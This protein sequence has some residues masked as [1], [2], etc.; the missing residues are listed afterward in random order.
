MN[1]LRPKVLVTR[2]DFVPSW[3]WCIVDDYGS[4]SNVSGITHNTFWLFQPRTTLLVQWGYGIWGF[5]EFQKIMKKPLQKCSR[6]GISVCVWKYRC[7]GTSPCGA[8]VDWDTS[9]WVWPRYFFKE[10]QNRWKSFILAMSSTLVSS[11]TVRW[12]SI[13]QGAGFPIMSRHVL[14]VPHP[15]TTTG[16]TLE[17]FFVS[18]I[19]WFSMF[20]RAITARLLKKNNGEPNFRYSEHAHSQKWMK[21]I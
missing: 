17:G 15:Y 16:T 13:D 11:H 6:G 7:I 1:T 2:R 10:L 5:R 21:V 3:F 14:K 8:P 12:L 20:F 19:C 9:R 18:P 4:S